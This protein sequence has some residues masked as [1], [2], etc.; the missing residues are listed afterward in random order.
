MSPPICLRISGFGHFRLLLP[1]CWQGKKL[2]HGGHWCRFFELLVGHPPPCPYFWIGESI[3]QSVG[4]WFDGDGM[5]WEFLIFRLA[6]C[7]G[8]LEIDTQ[9][10][11]VGKS[12]SQGQLRSISDGASALL[13]FCVYANVSKKA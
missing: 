1:D 11:Q 3:F 8:C 6:V 13:L 2:R 9:V 10:W 12:G 7:Y 4:L 5:M